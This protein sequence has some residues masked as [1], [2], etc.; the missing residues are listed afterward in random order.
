MDALNEMLAAGQYLPEHVVWWVTWMQVVL[1]FA[2][3]LLVMYRTP[4][5]LIAA[6]CLNF[7]IAY[8]VFVYEGNQVT[9][10]YGLGH[11]FWIWPMI[12][13]VKDIQSKDLNLVYRI[14]AVLAAL[15][16]A[17]RLM[18]DIRDYLLW[19]LGDRGSILVGVPVS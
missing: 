8:L 5:Y 10:L 11:L 7:G 12:Y 6:Q 4:R 9:R 17:I 18:F 3:L 19:V 2:P 14:Y 16:I 13:F 15:T 1:I